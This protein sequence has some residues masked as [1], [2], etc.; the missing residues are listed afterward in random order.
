MDRFI[1]KITSKNQWTST[2][3][4][5]CFEG[6]GIDRSDGF[7]HFSSAAQLIETVSKHFVG[8]RELLIIC[9]D[10]DKLGEHLRWEPSRG[11]DLFPHLYGVLPLSAV[12]ETLELP[13][14]ETG[15]HVFPMGPWQ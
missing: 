14:D 5:G 6:A 15:G 13:W 4:S 9:V 11:G 2:E 10:A 3:A 7:I 1:Y 8:K 12:V